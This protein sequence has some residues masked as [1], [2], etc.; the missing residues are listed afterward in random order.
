MNPSVK[1]FL[2]WTPRILSILYALFISVFAL[3]VFGEG[4]GFW[5]TALALVIHLIPTFLLVA[6]LLLSWRREWIGGIVYLVLAFAYVVFTW[7]RF[8][9]P[10]YAV[11][12]GP[13]MVTSGFF[14]FDWFHREGLGN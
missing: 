13:L 2:H 5:G 8:P 10:T 14:L 9:W 6:I 12:A 4:N 11:I 7:G 1:R 3:D